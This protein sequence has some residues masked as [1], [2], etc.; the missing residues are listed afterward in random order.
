MEPEFNLDLDEVRR[1]IDAAEVISLFFPYFRKTLLL[2]ARSNGTEGPAAWVVDMVANSDER[3]ESLRRLRPNFEPPRALTLV[4]WPRF[5]AS[6]KASGVW[7][8]LLDRAGRDA[9]HQI[10]PMLE[11]CYRE[12]LREERE[13][14]RRAIAGIGYQTVWQR[15]R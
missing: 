14:Y 9:A 8:I 11:R 5:V 4:P 12:L 13:E 1:G 3:L 2:D 15:E 7:D 6:V 10:E